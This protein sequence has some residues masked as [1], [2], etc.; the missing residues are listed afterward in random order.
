MNADAAQYSFDKLH[1]FFRKADYARWHRQE[2]KRHILRSQL[3]FGDI[4]PSRPKACVGCVHYH[5]VTYGYNR[6]TRT[7][8]ICGY[9]P[10]GW[11]SEGDCPDWQD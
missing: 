2:S 3:G 5:G 9:H 7:T 1:Y 6:E 8:L 10:Y 11:E 4:T